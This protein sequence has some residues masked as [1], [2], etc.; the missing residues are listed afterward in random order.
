MFADEIDKIGGF[1][2]SS[3]TT[4]KCITLGTKAGIMA[5]MERWFLIQSLYGVNKSYVASNTQANEED[6]ILPHNPKEDKWLKRELEEGGFFEEKITLLE[7][8][9]AEICNSIFDQFQQSVNGKIEKRMSN[10]RRDG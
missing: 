9:L 3:K 5:M 1:R 10:Y 2:G 8:K 4:N 7:E 6:P